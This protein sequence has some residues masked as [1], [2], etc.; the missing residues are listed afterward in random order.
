MPDDL[1]ARFE[2]AMDP[3]IWNEFAS[4]GEVLTLI[5]RDDAIN[6]ALAIVEEIRFRSM[7]W[8]GGKCRWCRVIVSEVL[9]KGLGKEL[10][11]HRKTCRFYVGPVEHSKTGGGHQMLTHWATHC[12]C[13]KSYDAERYNECPNSAETW[14]GPEPEDVP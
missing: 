14:R 13:G 12:T 1:R 7:H 6:A 5:Q 8:E 9:A 3:Y 4:T 10:Q 2:A 11:P